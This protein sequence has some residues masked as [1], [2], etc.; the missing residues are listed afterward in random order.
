V[1]SGPANV[2]GLNNSINDPSGAGNAP[3]V[4]SP[5]SPGTNSAGTANSSGV[6]SGG[7]ATTG[8]GSGAASMTDTPRTGNAD[9]DAQDRA[10]DRKI[11]S[12]CKGC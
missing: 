10:V 1:P 5:P 9:V 11:K 12:I 3:K 6:T 2:G 8:M 4:A 7:T